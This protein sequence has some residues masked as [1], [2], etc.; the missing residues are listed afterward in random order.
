VPAP[1]P[2]GPQP[3]VPDMPPPL[4]PPSQSKSAPPD[5]EWKPGYGP[6]VRLSPPEVSEG[7]SGGKGGVQLYP[8]IV[9]DKDNQPPPKVET[10]V[11]PKAPAAF[12]VGIPQFAL[13]RDKV[14]SGL[15]PSLDDGLDWLQ[16]NGYQTVLCLH[17]PGEPIAADRKQV[18]NRGM[19]FVALEVSPLAL[20]EKLIDEFNRLVADTGLQPL[21][22]YDRDGALAGSLWYLH[23]R[24][25]TDTSHEKALQQAR[26]LGLREDLDG[27]HRDMWLAVQ[28]Y[29]SDHPR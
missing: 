13:V 27:L 25:A 14:A 8:P 23:F 12:P 3:F 29:L 28:K 4:A 11:E 24:L 5:L 18:E 16:T 22:V 15:R 21:F 26:A 2:K 17:Q 1:L 9:T 7:G 6:S 19:K 10:K 20:K